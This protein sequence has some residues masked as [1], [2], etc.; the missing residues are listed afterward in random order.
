MS[1]ESR[2][3]E[4]PVRRPRGRKLP[5]AFYARDCVTVAREVLG[6]L[7]HR[8]EEDGSWTVGRIVETEA[9]V[10]EDD[11]A[12]HAAA[13]LTSRTRVLYGPPGRA[14]VYFTYGMHYLLNFVTER[15]GFPAAVLIRAV[16]P[17]AGLA[18]MRVRRGREDLLSLAS[19]PSRLCQAFGLDLSH[20]DIPLSGP[21]LTVRDDG[22]RSGAI[23]SGP[24]V[25]IRVGTDR[26]WRFWLKG[27][28]FVSRGRPGAP[29]RRRRRAAGGKRT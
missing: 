26:A 9:Y 12:C 13:G 1:P 4:E 24:R 14:Y 18:R 10:G 20:N 15:E 25:G 19:G 5:V 8:R 23:V 11:P 7:L 21:E 2:A 6:C 17:E 27:D 28:P 3:A 16:R 29:S 22:R